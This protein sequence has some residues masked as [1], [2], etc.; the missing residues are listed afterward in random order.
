MKNGH[1]I[2][3]EEWT[4]ELIQDL[5]SLQGIDVFRKLKEELDDEEY[6]DFCNAYEDFVERR[7]LERP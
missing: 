4:D 7:K 6:L 3:K 2:L 1:M 5:L